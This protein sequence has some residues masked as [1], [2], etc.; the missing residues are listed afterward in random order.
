V[1]AFLPVTLV[2]TTP[3]SD[4]SAVGTL[5]EA[6]VSGEVRHKGNIVLANGAMV[7][8]RIRRL[9]RFEEGLGA[10][11]LV[12]LEFT[13]AEGPAGPLRFFAD[14]LR[15]DKTPRI[16]PVTTERI[17]V[18]DIRPN[19]ERVLLLPQLPGVASFFVSG[20]TFAIPSGFR[21]TWRTRGL[22]R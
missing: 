11:F 8:G 1:P 12:G 2:L 18:P 9:E 14:F 4:R 17:P 7:R 3:V 6:K 19:H 15:I 20:K 10:E 13:E 22:I 5:I 16:R 21:M